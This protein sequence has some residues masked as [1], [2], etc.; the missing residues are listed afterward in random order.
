MTTAGFRKMLAR[1]SEASG[2]A[3]PV[4]PHNAAARVRLQA[5]Q[6]RAGYPNVTALSRTPQQPTHGAVYRAASSRFNN[7]WPDDQKYLRQNLSY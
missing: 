1:T 5:G 2:L 6:R 4:H 3:F 7:F